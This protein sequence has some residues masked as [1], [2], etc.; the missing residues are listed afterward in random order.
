MTAQRRVP[1]GRKIRSLLGL[2]IR[3]V[4][5]DL[6]RRRDILVELWGRH[7]VR[8]PFLDT[9]FSRYRT[10]GMADL[11]LLEPEEVERV[12]AFYRELDDLR[13]YLAYTEDMPRAMAMVFDSALARLVPSA[14]R[15]IVALGMESGEER[16][17]PPWERPQAGWG[18]DQGTHSPGGWGAVAEE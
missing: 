5:E 16:D 12:E 8:A 11:L 10:L 14:T 13:F 7:R 18:V 6:V 9:A 1:A 15:A 2:E 3:R 4:T 17:P